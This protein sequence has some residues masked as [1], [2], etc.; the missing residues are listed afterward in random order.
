MQILR[1]CLQWSPYGAQTIPGPSLMMT[2]WPCGEDGIMS[3]H[4]LLRSMRCGRYNDRD[5]AELEEHERAMAEGQVP[6]NAVC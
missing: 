1:T 4:E 6:Q 2:F 3:L 5:L